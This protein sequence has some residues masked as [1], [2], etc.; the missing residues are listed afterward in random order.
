MRSQED[1]CHNGLKKATN[2]LSVDSVVS[3][4][5]RVAQGKLPGYI[6]LLFPIAS[7]VR[8]GSCITQ[9]E[10]SGEGSGGGRK[11]KPKRSSK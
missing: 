3:L 5:A 7:H 4:R 8:D 11:K 6:H 10:K 2:T 1:P 9:L